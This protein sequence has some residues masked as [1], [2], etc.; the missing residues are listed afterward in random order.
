MKHELLYKP[1]YTLVMLQLEAGEQVTAETGAMV[2]MSTTISVETGVQGGLLSGLR[3]AVLGGESFFI[4]TFTANQAG[5]ISFAPS[6]PGDVLHFE[7]EAGRDVMVQSGG[8]LVSSA[9]ITVDTKWAGAKSFFAGEGLFLVKLSGAG[10]AFISSYGAIH[11]K[12]LAAGES[13]VIDTG[14]IVGFEAGVNYK[15]RKIGGLK[16][17]LAGGEGLVA[18]FSGPGRV[19]MQS[20]NPGAFLDWLLPKLPKSKR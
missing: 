15:V 14:H 16:T 3:R 11:E 7:L 8:Y 18:E 12:N 1:S 4:N 10:D 13:Y 19:W 5:E 6:L 2:S 9:G 17:T 20:R